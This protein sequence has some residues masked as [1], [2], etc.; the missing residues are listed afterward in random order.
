MT[1][2]PVTSPGSLAVTGGR[3]IS[4]VPSPRSKDGVGGQQIEKMLL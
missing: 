2:L 4:L 3:V 1:S